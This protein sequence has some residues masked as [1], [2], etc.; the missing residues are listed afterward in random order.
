MKKLTKFF[1]VLVLLT[2]TVNV[3]A[4]RE[5]DNFVRNVV[6]EINREISLPVMVAEGERLES[7]RSERGGKI[8]YL[9]TLTEIAVAD[10]NVPVFTAAVRTN[11]IEALSGQP[12]LQEFR[13]MGVTMVYVYRDNR[14]RQ[15]TRIELAP[16]EY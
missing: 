10:V 11:L 8:V 3:Y 16:G 6:R 14:R 2:A 9:F 1:I 12:E 13:D 5:L 7:I 15:I 4:N